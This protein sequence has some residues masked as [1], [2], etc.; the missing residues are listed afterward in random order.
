MMLKTRLICAAIVT[1]FDKD[2]DTSRLPIKAVR[3]AQL[4]IACL[5]TQLDESRLPIPHS[6]WHRRQKVR[7]VDD[8]N[9]FILKQ[10]MTRERYIR[11]MDDKPMVFQPMRNGAISHERR[12]EEV[13][14]VDSC[15]SWR[16]AVSTAPTARGSAWATVSAVSG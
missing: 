16:P 1:M 9:M 14:C 11:L 12:T 5:L 13:K 10:H 8:K 7:L 3:W 6:S 2:D 15:M 4:W